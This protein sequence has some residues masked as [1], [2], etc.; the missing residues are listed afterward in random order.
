MKKI[1]DN[2][3]EVIASYM[4]DE[5]REQ[6]H[7]KFS[8]CSNEYFVKQY[9]LTALKNNRILAKEF[10]EIIVNEFD[11]DIDEYV[12]FDEVMELITSGEQI[13]G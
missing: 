3:M 1:A 10:R 11:I 2:T 9:Y 6:I 5:I 7:F 8:P 12:T 4:D 13:C